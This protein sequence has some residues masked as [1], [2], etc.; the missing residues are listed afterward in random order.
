MES[1]R[2]T[3]TLGA[4]HLQT[5]EYYVQS[6]LGLREMNIR[7]IQ[8]YCKSIFVN[9]KS[10]FRSF[11]DYMVKIDPSVDLLTKFMEFDR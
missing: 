9:F 4:K 2:M 6:G 10:F 7:V 8:V 11:N 5:I 1:R 3:L